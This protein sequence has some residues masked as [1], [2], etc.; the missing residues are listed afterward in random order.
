M[1]M[2]KNFNQPSSKRISNMPLGH[3][4]R[5]MSLKSVYSPF[6]AKAFEHRKILQKN[7]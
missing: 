4:H 2:R 1:S 5:R 7:T 6:R 3:G